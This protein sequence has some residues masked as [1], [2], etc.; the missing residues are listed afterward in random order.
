MTFS[1]VV[2]VS[3]FGGLEIKKADERVGLFGCFRTEGDG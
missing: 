2:G 1:K 3:V